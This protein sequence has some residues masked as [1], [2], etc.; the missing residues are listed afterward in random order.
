M[1][2]GVGAGVGQE[3]KG[4][5]RGIRSSCV[6]APCQGCVRSHQPLP[7]P[8]PNPVAARQPLR[9]PT[10]LARVLAT[11]APW[12]RHGRPKLNFLGSLLSPRPEGSFLQPDT[13]TA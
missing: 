2:A 9:G 5:G 4:W 13:L 11:M 1:G 12:E 8:P 3:W 10:A 7:S 6:W